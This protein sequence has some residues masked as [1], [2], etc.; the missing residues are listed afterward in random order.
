MEVREVNTKD[1][2]RVRQMV[3]ETSQSTASMV[4]VVNDPERVDLDV[5]ERWAIETMDKLDHLLCL[6]QVDE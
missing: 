3:V 1:M 6:L 4:G 2:S 5:I